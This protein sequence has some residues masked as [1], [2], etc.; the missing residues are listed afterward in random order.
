MTV[1]LVTTIKAFVGLEADEKPADAPV[2]SRFLEADTGDEFIYVGDY[3][4]EGL[5][6]IADGGEAG[7]TI[8]LGSVTLTLVASEPSA[9]EVEAGAGLASR[10]VAAINGT[11]G[12]NT[13]NPDVRAELVNGDVRVI[14]RERG[15]D[16]NSLDSVYTEDD[17]SA[18]A[19][20][21]ATLGGG[22]DH[23]QELL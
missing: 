17:A 5:L 6:E 21:A 18:N 2:G 4:A 22:Y 7:D 16:G 19:F 15:S 23:W 9:G 13:A 14:A 3:Y 10:I 12:I 1:R 8:L 20:T 11:D